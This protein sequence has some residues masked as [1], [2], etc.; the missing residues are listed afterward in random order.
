[1]HFLWLIDWLF[2]VLRPAQEYFTYMETS[3]FPG[4]GLQNLGLC[5]ALRAIEQWGIF[6]VP[7]LLWRGTSVF[8]VSSEGPPHLFASYDTRG[9][10][11]DLWEISSWEGKH[12]QYACCLIHYVFCNMKYFEIN[13]L[14]DV[15]SWYLLILES[16]I[17]KLFKLT[18]CGVWFFVQTGDSG[19]G[20]SRSW[21]G[22]TS[23]VRGPERSRGCGGASITEVGIE[24]W[25]L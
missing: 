23:G 20:A 5:S 13:N 14:K 22:S 10:V 9:D 24:E 2:I 21:A 6:I 12:R 8:P 1:M 3:P 15:M 19:T 18:S 16:R 25:H 4:E 11:E 7:H 17:R